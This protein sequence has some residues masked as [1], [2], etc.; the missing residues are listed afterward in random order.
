MQSSNK[1]LTIL[2]IIKIPINQTQYE[3]CR[4]D[5]TKCHG[6][7]GDECINMK[8]SDKSREMRWD[9]LLSFIKARKKEEEEE[10]KGDSTFDQIKLQGSHSKQFSLT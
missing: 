9:N 7:N 8:V 2:V 5:D 3:N 1:I 6:I 4:I 10:R